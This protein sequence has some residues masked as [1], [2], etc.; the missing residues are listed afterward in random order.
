MK[1]AGDLCKIDNLGRIVIPVRLRRKFDMK[2]NDALEVFT[3]DDRIILQ[4]Y[5]P[6]CVFC[7]EEENLIEFGKHYVC[8]QCIG[9]ISNIG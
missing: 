7:S 6:T 8:R 4:K 9:K 1:R 2:A 3:E 5:I